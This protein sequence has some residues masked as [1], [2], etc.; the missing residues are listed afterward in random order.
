MAIS[1]EEH[2]TARNAAT[3]YW[4]ASI[5]CRESTAMGALMDT[6]NL[7]VAKHMEEGADW[8][9][10]SDDVI[11]K[12]IE[13][14]KTQP[15]STAP[16]TIRTTGNSDSS[17]HDIAIITFN[18][19]HAT[20]SGGWEMVTVEEV[21]H[22]DST[23]G[24]RLSKVEMKIEGS[25]L[26]LDSEQLCRDLREAALS[27]DESTLATLLNPEIQLKITD[28]SDA[29]H[30]FRRFSAFVGS[31]NNYP[32]DAGTDHSWTSDGMVVTCKYR[33]CETTPDK[34]TQKYKVTEV[35]TCAV[36]SGLF[37][38]KEI[39]TTVEKAHWFWG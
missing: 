2:F 35:Y 23:A 20:A 31:D 21:L 9:E 27:K 30:Q 12:I 25:P 14:W 24:H 33:Y 13:V 3:N 8:N 26:M 32:I 37:Q 1:T 11:S 5:R 10:S 18:Y 22:I 19:I 36:E 17:N 6:T 15:R 28:S 38:V 16:V 29:T 7:T 39:H 34:Q 4:T